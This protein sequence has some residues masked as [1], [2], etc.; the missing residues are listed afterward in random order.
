MLEKLNNFLSDTNKYSSNECMY[1]CI[2]TENYFLDILFI[3][4]IPEQRR[5][6]QDVLIKNVKQLNARV[7]RRSVAHKTVKD[8]FVS[9]R[10]AQVHIGFS[11]TQSDGR[12]AA[13]VPRKTS[14]SGHLTD[15]TLLT[16]TPATGQKQ[17]LVLEK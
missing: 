16:Q 11:I 6:F 2:Q 17:T 8:L 4:Y 10:S 13:G 5:F 12:S 3:F 9:G 7:Q 14:W 15:C 1:Y